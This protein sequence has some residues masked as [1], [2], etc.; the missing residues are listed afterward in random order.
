VLDN[1]SPTY[2]PLG[3]LVVITVLAV[4]AVIVWGVV[5]SWRVDRERAVLLLAVPAIG[6]LLWLA[7]GVR[8][9]GT[10]P[11]YAIF[12]AMCLTWALLVSVQTL[13]ARA[14]P[15]SAVRRLAVPGTVALLVVA[16]WLPHWGV[17]DYRRQGPTWSSTVSEAERAC[18]AEG[19]GE[20]EVQVPPLTG[21]W[22]VVLACD[23]LSD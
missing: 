12:P 10:T 9:G 1:F 11:R 21:E 22:P 7:L 8:L 6:A 20:V 3:P 23:E 14:E 4:G 16:A 15:G 17:P 19:L 18:V 13:A 5:A 2:S